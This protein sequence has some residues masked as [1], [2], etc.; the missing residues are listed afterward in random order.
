MTHGCQILD[1]VDEDDGGI[2]LQDSVDRLGQQTGL[3]LGALASELRGLDL[4]KWPSEVR[5][6]P[7]GEGGLARSRRAEQDDRLWGRDRVSRG[8][9]GLS[10]RQDDPSLDDLLRLVQS[11]HLVPKPRMDHPA[12]HLDQAA[13]HRR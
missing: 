11:L 7:L 8:Q 9:C 1:L 13:G 2:E 4:D 3:M 10:E 12:E 5:G 6:D